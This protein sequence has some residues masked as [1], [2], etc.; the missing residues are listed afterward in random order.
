[1]HA[2][3]FLICCDSYIFDISLINSPAIKKNTVHIHRLFFV[4]PF[5]FCLLPRFLMTSWICSFIPHHFLPIYHLCGFTKWNIQLA[6]VHEITSHPY[7]SW[8][9]VRLLNRVLYIC[10][11]ICKC[12]ASAVY[13]FKTLRVISYKI[14]YDI[15]S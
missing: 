10:F 11:K 1:M 14:F 9:G 15:L 2:S 6:S 4:C 12:N 13:S 5:P 7:F 8:F 3:V